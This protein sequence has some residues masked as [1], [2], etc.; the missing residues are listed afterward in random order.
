LRRLRRQADVFT[1]L[2]ELQS[3]LGRDPRSGR[4]RQSRVITRRN[5]A[6]RHTMAPRVMTTNSRL[7]RAARGRKR[8][9]PSRPPPIALSA[10]SRLAAPRGRAR[11]RA[12]WFNSPVAS[13]GDPD[14]RVLIVGL[15]PECRRNRTGRPLR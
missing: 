6:A 3:K 11:S 9:P 12:T 10:L 13:F 1:D 7:R 14:A 8:S 2:V 5:P 15:A 4:R